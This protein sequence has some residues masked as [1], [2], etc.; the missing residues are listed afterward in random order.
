MKYM[1][2]KARLAKHII[3]I[4]TSGIGDKSYVEP[5]AGGFNMIDK[6]DTPGK[7]YANDINKYVVAL[8]EALLGG[9][10]PRAYYTRG[11][12]EGFK[13]GR[14]DLHEI[15]YVGINCSYSG[16]WF[17]GFAGVTKTKGGVRNYQEEAYRNTMSQ[18]ANLAGVVLSSGSYLDMEIPPESHIYCDPP[19]FDTTNYGNNSFDHKTFWDWVRL[20]SKD[21]QVFVSEYSA[22]PDFTCVWSKDVVSSLSANG[23]SGKSKPSKESLFKF[24]SNYAET[25]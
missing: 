1:G 25:H 21:H 24:N 17:G 11:D 4:V 5:F 10:E 3:P 23:V 8:F 18:V 6:V 12:Y 13:V 22:P 2:S 7:R 15:G 19:Y 14:G 16:K 20:M 9:W